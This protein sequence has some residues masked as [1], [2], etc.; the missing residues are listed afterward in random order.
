MVPESHS[1]LRQK[2][3]DIRWKFESGQRDEERQKWQICSEIKNN[4]FFSFKKILK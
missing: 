1:Q 4:Y 2:K 3:N